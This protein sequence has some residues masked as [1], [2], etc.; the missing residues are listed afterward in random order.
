MIKRM[1][2]G[3]YVKL[4]TVKTGG[5]D[6]LTAEHENRRKSHNIYYGKSSTSPSCAG[7]KP[8]GK[9][10]SSHAQSRS[11]PMCV[12]IVRRGRIRSAQAIT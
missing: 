7:S 1:Q 4:G 9:R 5:A 3:G 10:R 2:V 12:N 11:K 6:R 8:G